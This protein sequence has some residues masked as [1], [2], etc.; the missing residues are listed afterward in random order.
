MDLKSKDLDPCKKRKIWTQETHKQEDSYAKTE[1]GSGEIR[2][3]AKD[4]KDC[5]QPPEGK[6]KH[7]S[8]LESLQ[9][10]DGPGDILIWSF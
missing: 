6:K 10:K 7:G 4:A 3:Q 8:I 5:Q 2:L 1:A 9:K